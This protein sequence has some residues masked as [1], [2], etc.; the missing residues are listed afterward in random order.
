MNVQWSQQIKTRCI[1]LCH[2]LF[3]KPNKNPTQQTSLF[4]FNIE[5]IINEKFPAQSGFVPLNYHIWLHIFCM[6]IFMSCSA[7]RMRWKRWRT[8]SDGTQHHVSLQAEFQ[9]LSTVILWDAAMTLEAQVQCCD[10]HG[11]FLLEERNPAIFSHILLLPLKKSSKSWGG[12]KKKKKKEKKKE[13][14][15]KTARSTI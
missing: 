9:R 5:L 1:T 8:Q 11:I 3:L 4:L 2:Q 10:C 12:I 6:C 7:G 15:V 14:R 13:K